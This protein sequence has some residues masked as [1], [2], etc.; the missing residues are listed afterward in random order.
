MFSERGYDGA[1]FQEVAERADLTRPAINHYFASKQALFNEVS[2]QSNALIIAAGIEQSRSE[3]TLV[4]RLAKF[5]SV[6]MEAEADNP[7][8]LAYMTTDVVETVRH[9]DL[10]R[11]N[12]AVSTTRDFLV[13]AINDA[14][15][16][17]E[18]APD[19]DSAALAEALVML[20][21]GIGFYVGFVGSYAAV[22]NILGTLQQLIAG[23]LWRAQV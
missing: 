22:E 21:C 20:I 3:Q 1:T 2:D 4:G 5:I 12:D 19:A 13:S 9:T 14:V 15:A 17:G 16:S 7:G 18:L 8:T 23:S 10:K 6:A 11:D